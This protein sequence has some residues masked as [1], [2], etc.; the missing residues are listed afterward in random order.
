MHNS[1]SKSTTDNERKKEKGKK[2]EIAEIAEI[3]AKI[4]KR[5]RKCDNK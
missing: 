2:R 3:E 5:R 4:G 1:H